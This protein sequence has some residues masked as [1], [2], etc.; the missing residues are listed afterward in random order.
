MG[1][2]LDEALR[3]IGSAEM[4]LLERVREL[5]PD[6]AGAD[7]ARRALPVALRAGVLTVE[8]ANATWRYVL[9]REHQERLRLRLSE[10]TAGAA[11]A[12]RFV[13]PGRATSSGVE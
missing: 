10:A 4:R 13:P 9:E 12:I 7:I 8:V 3:G 1:E 6:L 2:L 5:W 11:A